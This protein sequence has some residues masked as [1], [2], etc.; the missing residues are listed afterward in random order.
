[1]PELNFKGKEFVYNHHLTVPFRP[2]EI[3]SDKGIGEPALDGNLIIHGDNL[4]GLKALMPSHAG[5]I[6]CIFIDPPYNTGQEGW[7]YNDNVNSPMIR[8]WLSSN[9]IVVDDKLRHD[10]WACMMWPRLKLL[11]ELLAEDGFIFVT[12]DNHETHTMRMLLDEIFG[13]DNFRNEIIIRRGVK[14]VQAQFKNIESLSTGHDTLYCY[15]KNADLRMPKL[16]DTTEGGEAGKWDTFWRGTDRATMRYPLFG[17]QPESG[18]WR[19]AENRT[20]LAIANYKEYLANFSD[21][22]SLDDFFHLRTSEVGIKTDFVRLNEEGSVQ[23]Y[24]PP[25]DGKLLSDVWM[26]LRSAG[27]FTDFPHEKGL[28]LLETILRWTT[29]P[30]SVI[31][32]SF[33]G[34]GSTGHA[35]L[36]LNAKDGGRRKFILVETEDYADE[37]TAQRI[38]DACSNAFKSQQLELHDLQ[39]AS[40]TY[41]TLGDPIDMDGLLT[42]DDLPAVSA[43]AAL[44]YHTATNQAF[45]ESQLVAAPD[46]G[47]GVHR[48]GSA[49]GRHLWLFYKPDLGWLKSGNAA[50]SLSTARAIGAAELGD[51]LVFAPAKFV[52]R[53]LLAAQKLPVEYAPLP[54]ALYRVETA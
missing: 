48:L 13:E 23:Y 50:L 2:L 6:D 27:T 41:C 34:S 38:R 24:V 7:C 54:Y 22:M 28:E 44:L 43:L 33:A 14:N 31:L 42:G 19:W 30:N 18:Q 52:S 36:N 9:P 12:I 35:V 37:V 45:D 40:F 49:N 10:K 3:Q 29:G 4:H 32:D 21:A 17:K 46:I 25:R 26:K 1:M 39:Q 51:H 20:N 11:H 53:E 8:E 15:S 16:S 5:K 47:E